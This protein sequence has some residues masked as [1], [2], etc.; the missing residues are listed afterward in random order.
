MGLNGVIPWIVQPFF[1]EGF[2]PATAGNQE[3]TLFELSP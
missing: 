3:V 1:K 2:T